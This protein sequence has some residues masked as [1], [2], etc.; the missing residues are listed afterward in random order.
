MLLLNF[1]IKIFPTSSQRPKM[2]FALHL[3]KPELPGILSYL[4]SWLG[5]KNTHPTVFFTQPLK[6]ISAG[7][8]KYKNNLSK[9]SLVNQKI[10]WWNLHIIKMKVCKDCNIQ[11]QIYLDKVA[12]WSSLEERTVHMSSLHTTL[13]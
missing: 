12:P 3:H 7:Q 6:L 8:W 13:T 1:K 10:C 9:M 4:I 11:Y 5:N 2:Y